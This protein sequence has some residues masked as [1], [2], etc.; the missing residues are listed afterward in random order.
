MR[1]TFQL[2]TQASSI[3]PTQAN[4]S[5]SQNALNE[6]GLDGQV[7]RDA[8][9]KILGPW[10]DLVKK[11]N[12]ALFGEPPNYS[13]EE[14]AQMI[15]HCQQTPDIYTT[16][17]DPNCYSD[18]AI[19]NCYISRSRTS[20]ECE[21]NNARPVSRLVITRD[22]ANASSE[23]YKTTFD[24]LEKNYQ[25]NPERF[26]HDMLIG[27][28]PLQ[29]ARSFGHENAIRHNGE[30]ATTLAQKLTA[31][32][33]Y[34]ER[35]NYEW[36]MHGVN[37]QLPFLLGFEINDDEHRALEV[38]RNAS[39]NVVAMLSHFS[40]QLARADA[41][42]LSK[43]CQHVIEAENR[44]TACI[45]GLIKPD[46]K[47]PENPFRYALTGTGKEVMILLQ[48]N[49]QVRCHTAYGYQLNWMIPQDHNIADRMAT[50]CKA[51]PNLY[52]TL[53][54]KYGTPIQNS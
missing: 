7:C 13:I 29:L 15:L 9:L 14:R 43:L 31:D 38:A 26:N 24:Q 19:M 47:Q 50:L 37:N 36:L 11:D 48:H 41:S 33:E 21:E 44:Y 40:Y 8:P 34:S 54:V 6:Y 42:T 53:Y 2:T 1:L 4:Q 10:V 49:Y 22:S 25:D 3:S 52:E 18:K 17:P 16:S 20:S 28:Y 12:A 35:V 27:K 39:G 32:D 51:N 5:A 45:S 30:Q 23:Y 46:C